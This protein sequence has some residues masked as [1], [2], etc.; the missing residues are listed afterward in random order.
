MCL[1][2][3]HPVGDIVGVQEISGGGKDE[4]I[5]RTDVDAV[6]AAGVGSV[7]PGTCP[8]E[9]GCTYA[10]KNFGC[11]LAFDSAIKVL[12]RGGL[13]LCP[14]GKRVCAERLR[15]SIVLAGSR[16]VWDQEHATDSARW[17]S[18]VWIWVKIVLKKGARRPGGDWYL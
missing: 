14:A 6:I 3:E 9:D 12:G 8:V 16:M 17:S 1:F 7:N 15:K 5:A 11:Q 18:A 2:L 13:G 10:R 4:R